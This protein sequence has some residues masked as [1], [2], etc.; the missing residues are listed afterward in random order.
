VPPLALLASCAASRE[1]AA[2]IEAELADE[3]DEDAAS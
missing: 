2:E 3:A 1:A